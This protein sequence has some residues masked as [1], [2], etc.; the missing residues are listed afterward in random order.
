MIAKNILNKM[1]NQDRSIKRLIVLINDGL[2]NVVS[3]TIISF[4][5]KGTLSYEASFFVF[6][7]TIILLFI[8][9]RIYDNVIKHIGASYIYR[10]LIALFIPH[11]CYFLY[12]QI[13]FNN[14]ND[15]LV[16]FFNFF[17]TFSLI[18]ISRIVAKSILYQS[19]HRTE[20]IAIYVDKNHSSA[21]IDNINHLN[22]YATIAIISDDKESRGLYING[23]EVYNTSDIQDLIIEKKLSKLFI[24]SQKNIIKLKNTILDELS[25]APLKIIEIP[26]IEDVIKGKYSFDSLEDL[27]LEDIVDRKTD[28]LDLLDNTN[29]FIEGKDVLITGAGGSIGSILSS[30]IISYNPKSVILLDHSESSLFFTEQKLKQIN[31]NV[32]IIT[33]LIDLSDKSLLDGMFSA[34]NIDMVYHA[35]AYKHVNM[36]ENN[37][38]SGVKNNII[39]LYYLLNACEKNNVSN[40]VLISTDKAV[41]PTTI[42]GMTKK[43]CELMM[44]NF[45]SNKNCTYS[46]VRFGNVFNSSGS[47][48]PIFKEQ[49]L[50]QDFL[51]V[52]NKDVTRYFM[53]IDEAVHLVI[54]ASLI[55]KGNE[56]FILDMGEPRKI[57]DI[58]KKMIHISGKTIRSKDNPNGDIEIKIIG[59]GDSEKLHEELS[60]FSCEKTVEEKVLKSKDSDIEFN[61]VDEKIK[62]LLEYIDR[63]DANKINDYLKNHCFK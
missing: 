43:F 6:Q 24:A 8:F 2:I 54:K 44:F 31:S 10:L 26:D 7:F 48:I 21:I 22:Q 51:T 61:N 45:K 14:L 52:T 55:S 32:E 56:M 23:V 57:L 33:K 37:I 19:P 30:Q 17:V 25:N 58:A 38:L 4:F 42:M 36:L 3:F 39:G 9:F 35:A 62:L 1:I 29:T 41:K 40:F 34:Y 49:I 12:L 50:N 46:A 20:N 18:V 15:E 11:F 27:S 47:V 28:N 5:L 60:E 13:F 59:L 53:S 63:K 16:L